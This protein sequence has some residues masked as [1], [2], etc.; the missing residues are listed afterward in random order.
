MPSRWRA[1]TTLGTAKALRKAS[2]SFATTAG[3][4]PAGANT[5]AHEVTTRPA[6]PSSMAVG[7]LGRIEM[8]RSPS[9]ASTLILSK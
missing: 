3:G 5:P 4:V 7:T 8:R 1:S 2:S 6:T 9:E